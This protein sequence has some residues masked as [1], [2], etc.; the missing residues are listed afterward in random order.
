MHLH[1]EANPKTTQGSGHDLLSLGVRNL[2]M[3]TVAISSLIALLQVG[4]LIF[5]ICRWSAND[6][7]NKW[8]WERPTF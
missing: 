8:P 1:N 4:A 7:D 2:C 5:I 3:L 6:E